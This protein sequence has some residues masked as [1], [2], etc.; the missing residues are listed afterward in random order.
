MLRR[1][2]SNPRVAEMVY[3]AVTQVVL[4]FGWGAWGLLAEMERT[5]D[6]THIIF[7]R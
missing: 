6:G 5:V 7:L 3:R 2:G 4:L 1:E